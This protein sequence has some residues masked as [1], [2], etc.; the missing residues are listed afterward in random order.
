M[1]A[2]GD[3]KSRREYKGMVREKKQYSTY[4][5]FIFVARLARGT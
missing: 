2:T 1:D 3:L 5:G 4:L